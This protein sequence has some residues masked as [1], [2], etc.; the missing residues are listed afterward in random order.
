[1]SLGLGLAFGTAGLPH[2]LMR[3]FT[4]SSAKEARK[5]VVYASG[6]IG[7]AVATGWVVLSSTV[8]VDVF[9]FAQPVTPFPNPGIVSIPL[10]FVAIWFFSVTD[11][12]RRARTVGLRRADRAQ[13]HRYRG[14]NGGQSL[15]TSQSA[16]PERKVGALHSKFYGKSTHHDISCSSR[17]LSGRLSRLLRTGRSWHAYRDAVPGNVCRVTGRPG[18]VLGSAGRTPAMV[19]QTHGH[20]G[21][22]LKGQGIYVYVTLVAGE[23]GAE[24]LKKELINHVR[25]TIGPIA[26]PDHL[27]WAPAL[28]KTRSGKIMRRIL[29]KI[30]ENAPDQ[31]GD[32]STLADPAVVDVLVE[33]RLNC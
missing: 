22:E 16:S 19:S 5:S 6:F 13:C 28:P 4:V 26:T 27:Q 15:T 8:W 11:R 21:H 30:A 2:I 23:E 12:T 31:L 29:R 25:K 7:L 32:V 1:L 33:E 9:G 3:F 20:Q 14:R 10:A 24:P 18:R 17:R